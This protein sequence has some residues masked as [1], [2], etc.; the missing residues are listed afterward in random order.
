MKSP[1]KDSVLFWKIARDFLDYYLPKMRNVSHNTIDAYRQSLN[2]FI[3]YLET[4]KHVDR[5]SMAFQE[6]SRLN[7]GNYLV[8]MHSQKGLAAKT[9]NLRITAIRSFMEYASEENKELMAYY[10]EACSIKGLKTEK[11][12]IEF[13]ERKAMKALL[14]APDISSVKGRRNRILLILLYDSAARV[15]EIVDLRLC[16]LHLDSETPFLT[17]YGK[18]RKYRNVPLMEKTVSHLKNYLREFYSTSGLKETLPLFYS[19]RDGKPHALSTDTIELM[20]KKYATAVRMRC[21]EMP[22]NIH[23]HMIRKTRAMDLYQ[24][25]IPLVHIMQLLGH[26]NISTT[27]G[28]YAFATLETLRNSLQKTNSSNQEAEKLWKNKKMLNQLYRL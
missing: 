27:S 11:A 4:E 22:E 14:T 15:Q 25:G 21:S 5:K 17:I 28:F 16:D 8:W 24:E 12:A 23:C 19:L 2:H 13:L 9:C 6:F 10:N 18:G 1:A 26:E 7:I 3:D 20:L